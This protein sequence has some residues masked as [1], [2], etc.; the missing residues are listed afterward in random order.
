MFEKEFM[1]C[2]EERFNGTIAP[3]FKAGA[4]IKT[5][6]QTIKKEATFNGIHSSF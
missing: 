5:I 4:M 3:L 1:L 6:I 2:D